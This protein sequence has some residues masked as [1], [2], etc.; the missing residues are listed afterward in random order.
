M[1]VWTHEEIR[2]LIELEPWRELPTQDEQWTLIWQLTLAEN[3]A[4]NRE[5]KVCWRGAIVTQAYK[6]RCLARMRG[7]T[8]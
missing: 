6:D 7:A 5:K 8:T 3:R 1:E 2:A 4:W